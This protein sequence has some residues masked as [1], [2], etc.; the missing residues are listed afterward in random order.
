MDFKFLSRNKE[1]Q[2]QNTKMKKLIVPVLALSL[3]M[4]LP[5][6]AE[7]RS[8]HHEG[9]PSPTLESALTNL[10]EGNAKLAEI[11]KKVRLS[12]G[13]LH[14]VHI[15]SYTIENALEKLGEEQARLAELMEEVHIASEKNDA[16]TVKESGEAFLK[17]A[18]PLTK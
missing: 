15:L 9:K 3:S 10:K 8:A 14:E 13:D 17:A 1:T 18:A 6:F 5:S 4:L 12:P 2:Q 7:E 11:L 16:K